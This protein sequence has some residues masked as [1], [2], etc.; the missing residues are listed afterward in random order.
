MANGTCYVA[1]QK[2]ILVYGHDLTNPMYGRTF[3][4]AI[5]YHNMQLVR[6]NKIKL[7]IDFPTQKN[8]EEEYQ[9]VFERVKSSSFKKTDFALDVASSTADWATPQYIADGLRW[10][11]GK[12]VK[13]KIIMK[14]VSEKVLKKASKEKVIN[15]SLS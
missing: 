10:L 7:G 6:E 15:K 5:I 1:F 2:S 4:E 12:T 9:A 3:E 14:K 13:N 11:E 8:F